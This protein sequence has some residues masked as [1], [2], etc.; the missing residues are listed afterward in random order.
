MARVGA[1]ITIE[2]LVDRFPGANGYLIERGLPCLVCGEPFWGT[3]RELARRHGV[4][5]L[6]ELLR[7]LNMFLDARREKEGA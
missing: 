3:L 4:D 1:D 2:E 5:D 7:D 6:N